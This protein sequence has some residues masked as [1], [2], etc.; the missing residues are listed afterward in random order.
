MIVKNRLPA[1]LLLADGT[2][3]TG[4]S[5]GKVGTAVGEICYNT[6]NSGYEEIYT[7]PSYSG[8]ILVNTNPHIGNYGVLSSERES[9]RAH[10]AGLIVRNFSTQFSRKLATSS[11]DSFLIDQ[12]I[13]GISD[14]D[15]R[16]LVKHIRKFGSMNAVI[17]SDYSATQELDDFLKRMPIMEGRAL[18]PF[19]STKVPYKM[20]SDSAPYRI[21]II[22]FG[23]K[24][25]ILNCLLERGCQIIVFPHDTS[26]LT[27]LSSEPD[28][29]LLSNGPGD[30]AAMV[31]EV[32]V[33]KELILANVPIFGICLGHQL[34]GRAVG[35][36][37]HKMLNG[38]RGI[39]HAVKNLET[40]KCEITSQ[41][42]GFTIS[43]DSLTD[44]KLVDLTHVN[45]NDGSV[46][47]I[48]VK[49][50]PVF[51]VQFHP[52]AAPGPHDSRYLFDNFLH[53][54]KNKL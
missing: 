43:L 22:D 14:V 53:Q 19:V 6:G 12:Q 47:G 32:N 39:N 13:V 21:A 48:R 15:T 44:N 35:L 26:V 10:I 30:P 37:T 52:E 4:F 36:S 16:T 41:N 11:L 50:R 18:A 7:D 45:L 25:H 54:F 42:H 38:H 28:G 29:V 23:I 46:E 51:A 8:Q 33:V 9:E 27:I 2:L 5:F 1:T 20:G 24:K 40:G 34:I 3:F 17:S 49:D 31:N